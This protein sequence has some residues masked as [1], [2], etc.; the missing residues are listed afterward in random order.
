MY[1]EHQLWAIYEVGF[2][3]YINHLGISLLQKAGF[4][5]LIAYT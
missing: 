1:F 3:S 2:N 5:M 4:W